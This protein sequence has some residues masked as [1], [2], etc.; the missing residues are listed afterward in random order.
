MTMRIH[1][2]RALGLYLAWLS[3]VSGALLVA[4]GSVLPFGIGRIDPRGAFACLIEAELFFV[5]VVWPFFIPRLFVPRGPV[6]LGPGVEG[7]LLVLQVGILFLVALP[8]AFLTRNLADLGA[9]EFFV[10]HAL[11]ASVACFVAGLFTL[12]GI[13]VQRVAPWYLAGLFAAS[14]ALPFLHFLSLEYGGPALGWLAVLS[15]FWGAARLEEVAPLVSSAI[16]AL[17]AVAL[18]L[19]APYVRSPAASSPAPH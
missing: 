7:H 17:A 5:L 8:L 16:F 1:L 9:R 15:P 2:P 3:L 4:L 19:A 10:G 6:P 14:A 12:A 18:F 13:R 11:V